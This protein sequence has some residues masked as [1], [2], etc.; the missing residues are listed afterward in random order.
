MRR[1]RRFLGEG[2][3]EELDN[4]DEEDDDDYVNEDDYLDTEYQVGKEFTADRPKRQKASTIKMSYCELSD[5]EEN[6]VGNNLASH[7]NI[8]NMKRKKYS[9]D[10]SYKTDD[11]DDE[12][13]TSRKQTKKATKKISDSE[14]SDE[15]KSA[16][17]NKGKRPVIRKPWE[18]DEEQDESDESENELSEDDR[19]NSVENGKEKYSSNKSDMKIYIQGD[20]AIVELNQSEDSIDFSKNIM[21]PKVGLNQL[22]EGIL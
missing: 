11:D 22:T 9:D 20:E 16:S 18:S 4:D 13:F 1:K 14:A 17:K 19:S 5:N 7:R 8:S 15:D 6:S 21:P 10:D 2:S 3:D 12:Y